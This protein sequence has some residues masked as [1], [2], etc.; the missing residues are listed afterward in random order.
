MKEKE[1]LFLRLLRA[2][3]GEE[4]G[5]AG[6]W[7][8]TE[9]KKSFTREVFPFFQK[10]REMREAEKFFAGTKNFLRESRS[11]GAASGNKVSVFQ[12]EVHEPGQNQRLF[13]SRKERE[14]WKET[15]ENLWTAQGK[16]EG[17]REREFFFAERKEEQAEE[18]E[19]RFLEDVR[20]E[21]AASAALEQ[22]E[23]YFSMEKAEAGTQNVTIHIG[24]VKETA[25]VD[26]IMEEMTK[27]LWEAR[28][29]GRSRIE[30]RR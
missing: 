1:S 8:E 4:K 9:E 5:R 2:G 29:I 14:L 13:L 10:E 3:R 27:R 25:D 22:M 17:K 15:K 19:N 12:K 23:R 7:E 16:E 28:T 11:E 6:F 18:K 30:R 20:R 21:S 26:K 24:Q